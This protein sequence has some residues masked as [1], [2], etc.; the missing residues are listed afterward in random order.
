MSKL[1]PKK[2]RD[3]TLKI[4]GKS[5]TTERLA[6]ALIFQEECGDINIGKF[7]DELRGRVR[8]LEIEREEAND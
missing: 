3:T 8:E 4:D 7:L 2:Q 1:M 5:F 6:R